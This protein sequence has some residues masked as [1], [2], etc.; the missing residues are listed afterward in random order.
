MANSWEQLQYP[1]K[2]FLPQ[3]DPSDWF[4]PAWLAAID[5]A[6]HQTQVIPV[7]PIEYVYWLP[8]L[9]FQD[10]P[11]NQVNPA[12]QEVWQ[13]QSTSLMPVYPSEELHGSPDLWPYF[14]QVIAR[15]VFMPD[16]IGVTSPTKATP[17]HPGRDDLETAPL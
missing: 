5:Q 11:A 6:N 9:F 15:P 7:L 14:F 8:Y 2:A 3:G 17:V 4:D 16:G 10:E 13:N 1:Q 12:Y